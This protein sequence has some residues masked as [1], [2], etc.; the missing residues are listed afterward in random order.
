MSEAQARLYSLGYYP[1]PKASGH[2]GSALTTA[3]T[4][5]QKA[6]EAY[7]LTASGILDEASWTLLFSNEALPKPSDPTQ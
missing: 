5:F 7:G 2:A 4:D 1:F 6:H 3:V